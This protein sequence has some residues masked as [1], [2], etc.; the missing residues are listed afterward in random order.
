MLFNNLSLKSLMIFVLG[1]KLVIGLLH[2]AKICSDSNLDKIN[3]HEITGDYCRERNNTPL[4]QIQSGM[5]DI[6]IKLEI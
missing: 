5:G 3:N 6:F 4:N 2:D 1:G